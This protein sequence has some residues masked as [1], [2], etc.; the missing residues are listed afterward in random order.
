MAMDSIRSRRGTLVV[1]LDFELYWGV[2]DK[3]T[4]EECEA[5]LAGTRRVVPR[6]L[7][8]FRR[9]EIHA[10]WATV[11]LV[12]CDSPQDALRRAPEVKP[13]Y[14]DP[15][16]SPYPYLSTVGDDE[17]SR[18]LHFAPE[19][20][21]RILETPHQE[22]ATHT[23]SHL[24]C[25][26]PGSSPEGLEADLRSARL[27][28]MERFGREPVSLV[29]PRNQVD[30][31]A[32]RVC[33]EAGVLAYRGTEDTWFH[34]ARS[35]GEERWAHRLLRLLDAYLDISG[36]HAYDVP[37]TPVSPVDLPS[38]RFLRPYA[39]ALRALEP[40]RLRRITSA[41][42][43]AAERGQVFHLWWHPEN[44]GVDQDENLAFLR[45]VLGAF[46]A[47]RAKHGMRSRAM[48]ELA[49]EALGLAEAGH[50]SA[51][52]QAK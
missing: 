30:A 47:A 18:S 27:V 34:R 12:L 4:R 19:L 21:H 36:S 1:S 33:R 45:S 25:L 3:R 31:S 43:S 41:L 7:E 14:V 9:Q 49:R 15:N 38:S 24:Y 28:A 37:R 10:T 20:V 16:L 32:L 23:F 17:R 50:T 6:L 42:T 29:F 35:G 39:R 51:G 52:S 2:R 5:R 26:E 13:S 40:L 8:L 48:G 11:G 46:D 22:L 44:F